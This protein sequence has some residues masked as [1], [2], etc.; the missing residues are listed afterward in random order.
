MKRL[1]FLLII[2]V[3]STFIQAQY[4]K[5]V[6]Q[7]EAR[8]KQ[9]EKADR[10]KDWGAG[11]RSWQQPTWGWGQQPRKLFLNEWAREKGWAYDDD[12]GTLTFKGKSLEFYEKTEPVLYKNL[13]QKE[14][15]RIENE[16][17]AFRTGGQTWHMWQTLYPRHEQE[18]SETKVEKS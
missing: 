11:A 13:L 12:E 15:K 3:P 16:D 17:E 10:N 18:T 9:K 14:L 6:A 7:I 8:L 4:R 1:L 5:K 2:L